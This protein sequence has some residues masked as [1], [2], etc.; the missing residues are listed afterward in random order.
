MMA[1]FWACTPRLLLLLALAVPG[2][3]G[4]GEFTLS[5]VGTSDLHGHVEPTPLTV[6]DRNGEA[7]KVDR[8]G[9]PLLSGY[10]ED[11][12]RRHPVI[13]LDAG[14]L[15]QGTLISNLGEGQVVIDAYNLLRYN[16][17]A[18]GNH[19]FDYG[20][21]GPAGVARA[22]S[23]EDP[24][25]A[26]KARIAAARFPF[27]A[28]NIIDNATGR[29]I[30]W[31]NVYPSTIITLP[32]EPS[33][34]IGLIG[35]T[36]ED[37]PRTTNATNL[38][39]LT[40]AEVVPAVLA[41]ARALRKQGAQLV[42]LTV[43]EGANCKG[44][45]NPRDLSACQNDDGRVVKIAAALGGQVDAIVAGHT[46]SG[47]A[48]FVGPV[49]VIQSFAN[50]RAFG[51][52]DLSFHRVGPRLILDPDKTRVF[53][54]TEVCSVAVS[55]ACDAQSL[56]G[57]ESRPAI[58]EGQP[59]APS[60]TIAATLAP[61]RERAQAR[62]AEPL[63]FSLKQKMSR[64]YRD[65]SPLGAL[66]ADLIREGASLVK[67]EPVDFALQNGGGIRSD[68]PVG[69]LTY[70]DLFEIVPFDNRL[71]IIR[72]PGRVLSDLFALNMG[73]ASGV[74][75]PSGLVVTARCAGDAIQVAL[76]DSVGRPLLPD[77]VYTVAVSDFLAAG[78]DN[79]GAVLSRFPF[80]SVTFYDDA[81]PL[82][83]II[84]LALKQHHELPLPPD[85]PSRLHLS[86]PRPI[87][88]KQPSV[89]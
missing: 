63:G 58:Y 39:G 1:A 7:Q 70:G 49:P 19:E 22:G 75:V 72:A 12:R 6:K 16:A 53:P 34:R 81:P 10:L 43:H 5:I 50:G 18:I 61:Y 26:L 25:G 51:R 23:D 11:L 79:F 48:H 56:N 69:A 62:R 4:A 21:V 40:I 42:L 83:D 52:I 37:T 59:V 24:V 8:G 88:C 31:P 87:R 13:L 47:M 2:A 45:T 38:R 29:P 64:R 89:P 46:H 65:E 86:M 30:A 78:G 27:L 41:Q 68:L 15:F 3:A 55:A 33:L 35:A 17:A 67:G 57:T 84:L 85:G 20:P 71:A 77:R 73:S 66:L 82:R 74:L 32:E 60:A 9:L 44:F 76:S 80:G 54:P 36:A 28:A 14:D